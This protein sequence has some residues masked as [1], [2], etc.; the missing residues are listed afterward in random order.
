MG[1][2]YDWQVTP[3]NTPRFKERRLLF[4]VAMGIF[5][6]NLILTG[7]FLSANIWEH[8]FGALWVVFFA[9]VQCFDDRRTMWTW[10]YVIYWLIFSFVASAALF[11]WYRAYWWFVLY[12]IELTA[13]I[14]VTILT[15]KKRTTKSRRK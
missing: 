12:G 7:A 4:L 8:V 3:Q 1:K 14:I 11:L 6:L 2:R 15:L 10:G 13:F 5:M 9:A